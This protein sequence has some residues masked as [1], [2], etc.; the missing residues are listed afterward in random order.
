MEILKFKTKN[1]PIKSFGWA[2]IQ[3]QN[4]ALRKHS[5][6]DDFLPL[7]G[8]HI[9]DNEFTDLCHMFQRVMLEHVNQ[10]FCEHTPTTK[11]MDDFSLLIQSLHN[12]GD[13]PYYNIDVSFVFCRGWDDISNQHGDDPAIRMK[14]VLISGSKQAEWDIVAV[15]DPGMG[16]GI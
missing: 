2:W 16:I 5:N 14:T 10:V 13:E 6:P 1:Q 3:D 12:A 8:K 15:I 7:S 9:G 11:V 4:I